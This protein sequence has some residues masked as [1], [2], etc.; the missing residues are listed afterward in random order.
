MRRELVVGIDGSDSSL[1][2]VD[3]AV[4]E[5]V[6]HDVPLRLVYGTLWEYYERVPPGSGGRSTYQVVTDRMMAS[7]KERV[8]RQAPD[9]PVT[10]RLVG[11]DRVSALVGMSQEAFGVVVGSHGWGA[12]KG[13]LLGSTSL[14]VAAHAR[15]PVIVVRGED[16]NVHGD[17][18]RVTMG[19]AD[20]GES[21]SAVD[22]GFREA[23]IRDAQLDAIRA[24][25]RPWRGS[26]SPSLPDTGPEQ[27]RAAAGAALDDALAAAVE[28]Y[29]KVPVQRETPEGPARDALLDASSETDLLVVGARRRRGRVGMQLGPVNHAVLHHANCPV[30]VVPQED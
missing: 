30:A 21:S 29:P 22:F 16:A 8:T 19:V 10:T 15:C 24:W 26:P 14:A 12:A 4:E 1:R 11:E 18:G 28:T 27:H 7:A 20:E 13:T 25:R 5:A 17:F 9:L 23:Q 2:A 3:W 6:R